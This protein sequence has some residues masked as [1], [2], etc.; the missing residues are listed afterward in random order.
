M[1]NQKHD[2]DDDDV[3]HQ[4]RAQGAYDK[5]EKINDDKSGKATNSVVVIEKDKRGSQKDFIFK[6]SVI[7]LLIALLFTKTQLPMRIFM[8]YIYP[9]LF[10]LFFMFAIINFFI[11]GPIYTVI[12]AKRYTL[13]KLVSQYLKY[14]SL[15]IRF[16]YKEI[17]QALVYHLFSNVG[18]LIKYFFLFLYLITAITTSLVLAETIKSDSSKLSNL[19]G[20]EK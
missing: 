4:R 11:I 2:D 20:K 6:L 1:S 9:R 14:V 7:V 12:K 10:G 3:L 19:F 17:F 16:V 5:D 18:S 8:K 15:S 13:T